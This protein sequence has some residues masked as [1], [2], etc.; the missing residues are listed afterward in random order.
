MKNWQFGFHW[1]CILATHNT[2]AQR[3]PPIPYRKWIFIDFTGNDEPAV[4]MLSGCHSL[5]SQAWTQ[6]CCSIC[7]IVEWIY[8]GLFQ[9][10][11]LICTELITKFLKS[12]FFLLL[13]SYL[14]W[15]CNFILCNNFDKM[16]CSSD[17]YHA[18]EFENQSE[19]SKIG[20]PKNLMNRMSIEIQFLI[21][22][23][24][25]CQRN[26]LIKLNLPV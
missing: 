5:A 17:K 10:R 26:T 4:K 12:F 18:K 3:L 7:L 24:K 22:R 25:N 23:F 20:I 2:G 1:R 6:P 13:S 8:L 16:L 9:I 21:S 19:E 14:H 15:I 11:Y